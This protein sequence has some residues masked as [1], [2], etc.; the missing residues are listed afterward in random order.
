MR[1][2]NMRFRAPR[3]DALRPPS[4]RRN[5][6]MSPIEVMRAAF[7]AWERRDPAAL[8]ALFAED[9]EFLDP[10][11]PGVLTGPAAI[12]VGNR[13]A[14]TAV[15]DVRVTVHSAFEDG[16]RGAVE[17]WFRSRVAGTD[18]RFDFP[19]MAAIELRDGR[20]ARLAEY[21]DTQAVKP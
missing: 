3:K 15:E 16:A 12:E 11:K 1:R 21:F 7:D 10:L 19:F 6:A 18:V 4:R 8:G 17:G 5:P 14:M 20:I 2:I 13:D 9:G